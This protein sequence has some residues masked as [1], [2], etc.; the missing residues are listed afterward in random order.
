MMGLEIAAT[1]ITAFPTGV[2]ITVVYAKAPAFDFRR[3]RLPKGLPFRR[4]R[5][6]V[7]RNVSGLPVLNRRSAIW[8]AHVRITT[9]AGTEAPPPM[10]LTGEDKE[11]LIT[12][13]TAHLDL[14]LAPGQIGLQDVRPSR[15]AVPYR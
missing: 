3:E 7:S 5:S 9:T 2:P 8:T 15:L 6:F 10:L 14:R 12:M 13:L 11:W 4:P 1:R